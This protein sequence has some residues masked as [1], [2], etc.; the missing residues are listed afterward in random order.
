MDNELPP[1]VETLMVTPPG[2]SGFVEMSPPYIVL[3]FW[4]LKKIGKEKPLVSKG[5]RV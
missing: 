4:Y 1:M 3:G 5:L 2:W